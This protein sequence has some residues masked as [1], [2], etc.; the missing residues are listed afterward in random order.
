MLSILLC[1]IS[2][3][4]VNNL[5][6]TS[7][8]SRSTKVFDINITATQFGDIYDRSTDSVIPGVS[9]QYCKA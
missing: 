2:C 6:N 7:V 9:R 5:L 1:F 4:I 8:T 3:L